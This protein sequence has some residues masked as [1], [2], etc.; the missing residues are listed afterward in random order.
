M[1][2]QGLRN[3]IMLVPTWVDG[4]SKGSGTKFGNRGLVLIFHQ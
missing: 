2:I 4:N 1:E 3:Q